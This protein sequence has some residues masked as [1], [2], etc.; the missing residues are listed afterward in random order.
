M[1]WLLAGLYLRIDSARFTDQC[2]VRFGSKA[3]ICAA[4]SHVRFTPNS[5]RKS[6][7]A[8]NG[9]VRFTPESGHVRCNYRC[10][11]WANSGHGQSYSITSSA[12]SK[13]DWGISKPS[14]LAALR[15]RMN[16]NFDTRSI[17]RSAGL[18]PLRIL[19]TKKAARRKTATR[20]AP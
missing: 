16:W 6:R 3:D 1:E 9:H 11:L 14:A 7:H 20:S 8:A 2:H 18:V 15:L 17:G 12:R 4:I 5:D 10:P 19:S 13:M